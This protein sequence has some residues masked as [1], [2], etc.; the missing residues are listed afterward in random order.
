MVRGSKE[1][2]TESQ[3]RFPSVCKLLLARVM[4]SFC[5][6]IVVMAR[7]MWDFVEPTLEVAGWLRTSCPLLTAPENTRG[8]T[9][10]PDLPVTCLVPLPVLNKGPYWRE[11]HTAI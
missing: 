4:V 2:C 5:Q 11:P 6:C 1:R 8:G 3:G 10:I 9:I 7:C